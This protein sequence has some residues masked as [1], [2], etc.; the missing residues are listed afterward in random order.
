MT[1]RAD[2]CLSLNI[3]GTPHDGDPNWSERVLSW[4]RQYGWNV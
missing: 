1:Y 4:L 3:D 2:V